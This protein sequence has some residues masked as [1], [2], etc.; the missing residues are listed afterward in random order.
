MYKCLSL[1]SFAS[2]LFFLACQGPKLRSVYTLV[3]SPQAA[4]DLSVFKQLVKDKRV[5]MLGE[6]CH[7]AREVNQFRKDFIQYL[8]EE[9]DYE[10]LLFE[11]GIGE[12]ISIE[13]ERNELSATQMVTAGVTGPWHTEDYVEIMD[14]LKATPSMHVAGFDVQR[15]GRSFDRWV[16][17]TL[18]AITPNP[19]IYQQ[20]ETLYTEMLRLFRNR[21]VKADEAL[22]DK[23]VHLSKLYRDLANLLVENETVVKNKVGEKV[24]ALMT[25]TLSNRQAYLDYFMDFK[26]SNDYR[27]R[28][29]ARDSLMAD[30]ALWLINNLYPDKKVIINAHNF[31]ISKYNEKEL[32]MGEVLAEE[33]GEQVYAIGVFGGKGS[34][35]NNG[36]KPELMT[37]TK[38]K[39]D[40]QQIVLKEPYEVSIFPIPTSPET[41]Q[42]WLYEPILVNHSFINLDNDRELIPAK[43]FDAIIGIKGISPPKYIN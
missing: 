6:F 7:G 26:R 14:Y 41:S 18:P 38:A 34:Y 23:Y 33:L 27:A 28:W 2:F 31:H 32:T 13:Y 16:Q 42:N 22:E 9:L 21:K 24:A 20:V 36:R 10:L 15:T 19:E 40:I 1:L 17:K 3:D 43:A 29:T 12:G 4:P 8:H 11:S 39:H 5:V 30:N 37:L 25:R 35:A